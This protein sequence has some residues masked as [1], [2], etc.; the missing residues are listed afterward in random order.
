MQWDAVPFY[1]PIKLN[2]WN[3]IVCFSFRFKAALATDEFKDINAELAHQSLEAF[4]KY[5]KSVDASDSWYNTSCN[6]H[7]YEECEGDP[8]LDWKDKGYVTVFDLLQV[9]CQR[10]PFKI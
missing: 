4:Q 10:Q 6:T 2:L 7:G 9:I 8:S 3:I 1:S 5:I